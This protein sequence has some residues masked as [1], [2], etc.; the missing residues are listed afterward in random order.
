MSVVIPAFNAARTIGAT[1][2][3][4]RAQSYKALEIIVVDDGSTDE[5]ALVVGEHIAADARVR[6]LRQDNAGVATARN[7]GWRAA[8]GV[9]IALL[10]S[11]DLWNPGKIELQ[12]AA[13]AG[14]GARVGLAYCFYARINDDNMITEHWDLPAIQ[15]EVLD[16]ML[17]ENF[18]G[19]IGSSILVKR[20]VVEA[21]GGFEAGFRAAGAEGCDD[22]LFCCLAAELCAFAVVPE[23]LVGYRDVAGSLSSDPVRMLNSRLMTYQTL[24]ARHPGKQQILAEGIYIFA[25]W[26]VRRTVFQ[27]R[28]RQALAVLL[29]VLRRQPL[30]GLK[31]IGKDLPVL[32]VD[33]ARRLAVRLARQIRRQAPPR[34]PRIPFPMAARGL[35]PETE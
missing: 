15:G 9:L 6:L 33:L 22:Y 17:R 31:I 3:S 34:P 10:D 25:E 28:P 13:L 4:A 24:L 14:G 27:R 8:T 20:E 5:T 2:A 12:L 32:A 11:D 21:C 18:V 30:A 16:A 7:A 23:I 1:L 19:G 26:L 29:I 35:M